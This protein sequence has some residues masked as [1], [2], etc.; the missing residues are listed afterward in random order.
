MANLNKGMFIGRIVRKT[1]L[2]HLDGG[3]IVLE[4]ALAV[5][6][7][8]KKDGQKHENTS[9]IDFTLWGAKAEALNKFADKGDE[10]YIEGKFKQQNWVDKGT[11]QKR[12]R[13]VLSAYTFEFIKTKGIGLEKEEENNEEDY[14]DPPNVPF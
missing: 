6:D 13:L 8:Y 7:F 9:F 10:I 11:E 4:N 14:N 5:N 12:S 3:S 1:E 2:K